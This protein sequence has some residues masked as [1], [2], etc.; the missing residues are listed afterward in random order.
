MYFLGLQNILDFKTVLY[1]AETTG[2]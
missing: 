2:L 1:H